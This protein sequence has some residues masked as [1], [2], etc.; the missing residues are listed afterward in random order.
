M[1]GRLGDRE[2]TI[3]D[4]NE[5]VGAHAADEITDEELSGH[6]VP[7]PRGNTHG[8]APAEDPRKGDVGF[9]VGELVFDVLR[10]GLRPPEIVT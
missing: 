8:R 1:P 7:G 4:V 5:A 10:R 3:Q 2:L 6:R 9:R